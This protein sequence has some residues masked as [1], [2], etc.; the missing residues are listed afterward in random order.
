MKIVDNNEIH[1]KSGRSVQH[2]IEDKSAL[3]YRTNADGL[4]KKSAREIKSAADSEDFSARKKENTVNPARENYRRKVGIKV[5]RKHKP[6]GAERTIQKRRMAN[7]APKKAVKRDLSR[8]HFNR[9]NQ[10]KHKKFRPK[11]IKYKGKITTA[12]SSGSVITK[13]LAIPL[14]VAKKAVTKPVEIAGNKLLSQRINMSKTEDSGTE[15]MKLGLQTVDYV[16]RGVR[17]IKSAAQAPRKIYKGVKRTVNSTKR[18]VKTSA[19]AARNAAKA[20]KASA[21]AAAKAAKITAQVVKAA[22]QAVGKIISLIA[23]TAPYSLIVI[24]VI[25]VVLLL[26]Y[27]V[28][29]L[30]GAAGSSVGGIG[31]WAGNSDTSSEKDVYDNIQNFISLAKSTLESDVQDE[32]RSITNDF[33]ALWYH[34]NG[35]RTDE[36]G[37]KYCNGHVKDN[38][39]EFRSDKVTDTYYPAHDGKSA[40]DGY[41]KD[42]KDQFDSE[43]YSNFLATLYVVKARDMQNQNSS[44]ASFVLSDLEFTDA[45][46]AEMIRTVDENSGKYGDTYFYKTVEHTTG[47]CP[48]ENCRTEYRDDD[49]CTDS[50][51]NTYCGGHPYCPGEHDKLIVRLYSTEKFS[52]K[53]LEEIYGFSDDEKEQFTAVKEFIKAITDDIEGGESSEAS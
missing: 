45:D 4:A 50:D 43:F 22:A 49:C 30:I 12:K 16:R 47:K 11:K 14:N 36:Y 31:G 15:S 13:G 1:A 52:G 28:N 41:I 40:I 18:A 27:L 53:K 42:F 51:G 3:S 6:V 19:K 38:I 7:S 8:L 32:L 20:A 17:T 44:G 21:K 5:S 24:A 48:G 34:E 33:C 26:M 46:F 2:R 35:C 37:N 39:I 10:F 23:E 9:N 25:I 29:S